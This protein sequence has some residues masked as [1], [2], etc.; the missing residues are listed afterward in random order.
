M[1]LTPRL[2]LFNKSLGGVVLLG[3][4]ASSV[5]GAI[6]LSIARSFDSA[7]VGIVMGAGP[8]FDARQGLAPNQLI[9]QVW[10][11]FNPTMI[12]G[13]GLDLSSRNPSGSES[14]NQARYESVS[15]WI[16]WHTKTQAVELTLVGSL[17]AT[18]TY[19]DTT[20]GADP[21]QDIGSDIG[22][23]IR[24]GY[25]QRFS[26]RFGWWIAGSPTY[27]FRAFGT[28]T[29][30]NPGFAGEV[31]MTFNMRE[32]WYDAKNLSRSWDLFVRIPFQVQ[33]ASPHVSATGVARIPTWR[34]GIQIG[35]SV[36]F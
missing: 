19:F 31:G 15:T 27:G 5:S 34:L 6:P 21:I 4:F 26:Q 14:F 7:G 36:L 25:G 30:I 3:I 29:G 35:P 2:C 16:P 32:I 11:H 17:E 28:N 18:T 24:L 12:G 10:F 22:L 20:A 23:G 1:I 33:A 8:S 13:A 9:A